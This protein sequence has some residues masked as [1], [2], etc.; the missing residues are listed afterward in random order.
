MIDGE[1]IG[2]SPHIA[3]DHAGAG[4]L[5]FFLHGVGGN[6]HNWRDQL[7]ALAP[8]FHAAA[9]DARGYGDS[10]DYDGAFVF[11]D[12][13]A[14]LER[15]LDHFGA[16]RAHLVGQSMGGLVA[17]DFF[18]RRP[19][20]VSSLTLVDTTTGLREGQDESWI[21]E[22]LSARK[23]PLL[24]GKAPADIARAVATSLVGASASPEA[25]ERMRASIAALR[26]DS[27]IKALDAV[28]RYR[29][30]RYHA[31]VTVPTLVIVGAEDR[32]TPPSAA[33]RLAAGIPGARLAVIDGAGHLP[34]LEK[35]HV[36]NTLLLDFLL[37]LHG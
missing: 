5:V 14:D 13:C 37:A 4:E 3:V 19:Q 12:V 7:E 26:K 27:Y 30:R 31:D 22:F 18:A 25:R 28:T 10:D 35:P 16:G 9:W 8:H 36:F 23:K 24:E 11:A 33:R 34:N 2:P 6:R 17:Q 32:L 1:R 21:E 29:A 15:A 20:R